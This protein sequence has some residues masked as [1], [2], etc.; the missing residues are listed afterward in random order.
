MPDSVDCGINNIQI[1]EFVQTIANCLPHILVILEIPICFTCTTGSTAMDIL[2]AAYVVY[3]ANDL[4]ASAYYY[5]V[6]FQVYVK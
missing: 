5:A 2:Q 1:W 4:M 6:F 3:V